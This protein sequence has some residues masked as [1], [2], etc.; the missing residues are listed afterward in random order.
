MAPDAT[1]APGQEPDAAPVDDDAQPD[2]DAPPDGDTFDRAYVEKLRRTEAKTRREL[3]T[4]QAQLK[5]RED[6]EKTEAQRLTER[7]TA[8]E[9]EAASARTQLLRHEV[10]AAKGLPGTFVERLRGDTREDLEADADVLIEQLGEQATTRTSRSAA[11]DAGAR[12]RPADGGA[13]PPDMDDAIRRA[14]GRHP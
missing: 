9:T 5:D 3:R 7:V 13:T 1:P 6:A 4:A 10:A 12:G 2:A 14:A 11:F 8:A